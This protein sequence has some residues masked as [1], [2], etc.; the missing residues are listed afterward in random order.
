MCRFWKGFNLLRSPLQKVSLSRKVIKSLSLN[1]S[2]ISLMLPPY[3][4]I[5][6]SLWVC[7]RPYVRLYIHRN[8]FKSTIYYVVLL[9]SRLDLSLFFLRMFYLTLSPILHP[10]PLVSTLSPPPHTTPKCQLFC[11]PSPLA[12]IGARVASLSLLWSLRTK[13]SFPLF[14]INTKYIY[15]FF[16]VDFY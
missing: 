2:G 15:K 6:L 7:W 12:E 4:V 14:I 13:E 5:E 1:S 16:N 9:I 3:R 8:R 11:C 10:S